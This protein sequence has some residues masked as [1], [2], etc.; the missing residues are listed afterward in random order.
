MERIRSN[1]GKKDIKRM[2][3]GRYMGH[4]AFA[5]IQAIL[6]NCSVIQGGTSIIFEP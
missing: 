5:A 6:G 3:Q 2:A 4:W 1:I